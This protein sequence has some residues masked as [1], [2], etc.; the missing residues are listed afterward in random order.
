MYID[1][2]AS[3]SRRLCF[4]AAI[5]RFCGG[6]LSSSLVFPLSC[7][8][9]ALLCFFAFFALL[10]VSLL[11][12]FFVSLL[13]VALL[14][15]SD[16]ADCIQIISASLLALEQLFASITIASVIFSAIVATEM[17]TFIGLRTRIGSE[18]FHHARLLFSTLLIVY[19]ALYPFGYHVLAFFVMCLALTCTA[20]AMINQH[21]IRAVA[22]GQISLERPREPGSLVW[23]V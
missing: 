11:L 6:A 1:G 22:A 3:N 4:R 2:H 18:T 9:F 19:V 12:C 14:C 7:F 21:E 5:G 17:F 13:F 10:F 8:C 23:P 16:L 20:I 15:I